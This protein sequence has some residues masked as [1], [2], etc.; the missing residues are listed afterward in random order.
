MNLLLNLSAVIFLILSSITVFAADE[1]NPICRSVSQSTCKVG[2]SLGKG[3]NLGNMLDSPKE[4][5]WGVSY[6]PEFVE[7]IS[8]DF[9]H[10]RLPVRWS[11]HASLN[12]DAKID[13][14]FM[15][16]VESIVDAMLAKNLTV[17]LNVHHY[18]QLS[19]EKLDYGEIGVDPAVVTERFLN[20]WTQISQRFAGK[21]DK[22]IFEVLNEP[23]DALKGDKWNELAATALK[24]IRK[25]NPE[26]VVMIGPAGN[27]I[28]RLKEFKVPDDKNIIVTVH[29][30]DPAPFTLQG[31]SYMKQF[32]KGATCCD[33]N[34][35]AKIVSGLDTAK[36]W[37]IKNGYPI[38]IGEFGASARGALESR[39][40][41]ASFFRKEAE[42]RG[43]SWAYWDFASEDFGVYGP[44]KNLWIPVFHDA[45]IK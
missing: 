14:K 23:G 32:P 19:G 8:K 13:E 25:S 21:S 16:R 34:Q 18:R 36:S 28:P 7:A 35:K 12:A 41:Y 4:G 2:Q 15:L 27:A 24:V 9:Q 29:N 11:S 38:H 43:F 37:S 3:I 1:I 17:I 45:L 30:Y 42:L 6:Q 40:E 33:A 44:Y 31:F 22:L 39:V 10:V 26:R 20:I 5:Q